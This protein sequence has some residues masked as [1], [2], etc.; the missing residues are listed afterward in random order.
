MILFSLQYNQTIYRKVSKN[1]YLSEVN[2]AKSPIK[3]NE[4]DIIRE[5]KPVQEAIFNKKNTQLLERFDKAYS[6]KLVV[7]APLKLIKP[8]LAGQIDTLIINQQANNLENSMN[9]DLQKKTD[10]NLPDNLMNDLADTV[11]ENQGHV[12]LLPNEKMPVKTEAVAILR[13]Q[14]NN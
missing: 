3:L 12:W 13:Y 1:P 8:A 7:T 6:Q 4:Q 2:I 9:N 10:V 14:N 5:L 11:F